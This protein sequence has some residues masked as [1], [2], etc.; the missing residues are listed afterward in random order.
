MESIV[1]DGYILNFIGALVVIFAMGFFT[2]LLII[3]KIKNKILK[4][5]NDP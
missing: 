1:R 5:K 2:A 4:Y 3:E